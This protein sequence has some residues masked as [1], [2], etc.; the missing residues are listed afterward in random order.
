MTRTLLVISSL[1]PAGIVGLLLRTSARTGLT[2]W[3]AIAAPAPLARA[4]VATL[5][6]GA[7]VGLI[8][9][10]APAPLTEMAGVSGAGSAMIVDAPVTV[11]ALVWEFH[12]ATLAP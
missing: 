4:S 7:D 8:A 1:V 5:I 9:S 10:T 11:S 2:P 3:F 6:T 12:D